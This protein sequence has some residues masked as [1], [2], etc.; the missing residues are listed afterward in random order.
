ML[1]PVPPFANTKS[2]PGSHS[3][4]DYQIGRGRYAVVLYKSSAAC[5]VAKREVNPS[6]HT[7]VFENSPQTIRQCPR[8]FHNLSAGLAN[9]WCMHKTIFESFQ[10][11]S[12][13]TQHI[14]V[15]WPFGYADEEGR[16][17][18]EKSGLVL[19]MPLRQSQ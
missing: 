18:L 13:F 10:Y 19:R 15:P 4:K 3:R 11:S 6:I 5:F 16:R 2:S 14:N 9:I 1:L 17:W 12:A 7:R 8:P